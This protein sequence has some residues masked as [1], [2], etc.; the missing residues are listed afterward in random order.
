MHVK[1]ILQRK[2]F[3]KTINAFR[4]RER[5]RGC[6]FERVCKIGRGSKAERERER[7]RERKGDGEG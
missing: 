1:K 4:G 5:E 3:Y 2:F 6:V 7:E